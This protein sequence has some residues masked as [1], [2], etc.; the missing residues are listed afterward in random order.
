MKPYQ[1]CQRSKYLYLYVPFFTTRATRPP[2]DALTVKKKN[3]VYSPFQ[4]THHFSFKTLLELSTLLIFCIYMSP[5]S[6][7][8]PRATLKR[9][10]AQDFFLWYILLFTMRTLKRSEAQRNFFGYVFHISIRTFNSIP[11]FLAAR[12]ALY[13]TMSVCLSVCRSVGL[14]VGW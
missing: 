6:L 14:S 8:G 2:S 13:R 5:F 1:N 3:L 12:A 4:Y 7:R 11:I 9:S 10:D